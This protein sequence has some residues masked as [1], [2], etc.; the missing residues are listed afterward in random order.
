VDLKTLCEAGD[1]E[2]F[3]YFYAFSAAL[4]LSR[5]WLPARAGWR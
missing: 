5:R 4:P 2:A 1:P 3:L